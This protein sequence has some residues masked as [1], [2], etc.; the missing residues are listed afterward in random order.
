MLVT[1]GTP[2]ESPLSSTFK[3]EMEEAPMATGFPEDVD[4]MDAHSLHQTWP[5][6]RLL[7]RPGL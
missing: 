2:Q 7:E 1:L 4:T 6:S 3:A 5:G